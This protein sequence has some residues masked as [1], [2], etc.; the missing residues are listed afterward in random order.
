MRRTGTI[1]DVTRLSASEQAGMLSR[2][3]LLPTELV[4]ASLERIEAVNTTINAVVTLSPR[5]MDDARLL[6]SKR[7]EARG[8]LWGLPVGIKDVTPVASLRTTYGS[9]LFA[10]ATP[11]ADAYIVTLLRRAGAVIL[12]KTNTPEFAAGA[13]TKNPVFGATRNPWNPALSAGG[14]TGGGA[15]ALATGMVSLAE[16]TDLGGSL[17]IPA[18]FCGVVGLRPTPG[19]VPRWPSDTPWSLLDVAGPMARTARDVALML[20]AISGEHLYDP[21]SCAPPQLPGATATPYVDQ[22]ETRSLSGRRLA[23]CTDIA[24]IGVDPEIE[25]HCRQAAQSLIDSGTE[26]EEVELDLSA[27]REAFSILRG[28]FMVNA[29]YS[30]LDRLEELGPN[31]RG[32]IRAGLE[33][34][35]RQIARAERLRSEIYQ[36]LR[37]LLERYHQLL[38]PTTAVPPFPLSDDY[39]KTVAG[40]PMATYV[41]WFAP[42]FVISL[43]ALPAASVPCG[44]DSQNRPVGLQI[45]G[46]PFS[47]VEVLSVAKRVQ[48]VQPIGLPPDP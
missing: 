1:G 39:P 18:A 37:E 25:R 47:E 7:Q 14:S 44:L 15:A 34:S 33:L 2:G 32:N 35:A 29:H 19:L 23:Y 13:N 31:L 21:L 40:K 8:P 3:D 5:A 12:G 4:K 10:D 9:P 22:L 42:T 45:I 17:R 27:G 48:E 46:R 28:L 24:G 16:G 36:R 11:Q 6:E 26:V 43:A 20:D 38:T 41:D 30:R